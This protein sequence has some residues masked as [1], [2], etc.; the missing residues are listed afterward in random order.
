M[1]TSVRTHGSP[2][3][4]QTPTLLQA[5]GHSLNAKETTMT[6]MINALVPAGALFQRW[7]DAWRATP[8]TDMADD[9][10]AVRALADSYRKSDPGFASDL[11]AAADR[12][13]GAADA[14]AMHD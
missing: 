2:Y 7:L 3:Q 11:Y 13:E 6:T 14:A 9:A 10:A 4:R 12:H 8:K 5:I 1:N